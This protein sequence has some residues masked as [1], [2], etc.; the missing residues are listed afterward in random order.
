VQAEKSK[1]R[2]AEFAVGEVRVPFGS[3]IMVVPIAELMKL[4]L[5][6]RNN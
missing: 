5:I 1:K 6:M 3:K 2:V 4:Q